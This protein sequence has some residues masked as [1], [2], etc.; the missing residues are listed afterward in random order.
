M[1]R[2][3]MGNWIRDAND[4]NLTFGELLLGT[5]WEATFGRLAA[6]RAQRK[7]DKYLLQKYTESGGEGFTD[8]AR[9]YLQ[10]RGLLAPTPTT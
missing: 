6:K 5:A 4:A 10:T 7:L 1:R 9:S 3:S 8:D 2:F